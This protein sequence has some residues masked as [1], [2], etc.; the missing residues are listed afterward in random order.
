[1]A[2]YQYGDSH[3]KDTTVSWYSQSNNVNLY[4][5]KGGFK[6][7]RGGIYL[8]VLSVDDKRTPYLQL[9]V[10][11]VVGVDKATKQ[12]TVECARGEKVNRHPFYTHMLLIYKNIMMT[13]SNGNIF[14]V[15]DPLCG[16]FTGE[17]PTQRPVARSF[18]V[19]FDLCLNKRLSK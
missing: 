18:D 14:R 9:H 19:Y 7:K 13:S 2:S 4:N 12:E 15:T 16:E 6:V 17:F 10:D 3:Y 1:M 5:C 8:S 11:Q